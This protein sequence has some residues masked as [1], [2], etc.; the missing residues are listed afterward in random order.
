MFPAQAA[1]SLLCVRRRFVSYTRFQ[2]RDSPVTSLLWFQR[3]HKGYGFPFP[4]SWIISYEWNQQLPVKA[5]KYWLYF[6]VMPRNDE[7]LVQHIWHI[8]K[9]SWCNNNSKPASVLVNNCLS[10]I[11]VALSWHFHSYVFNFKK[12]TFSL[13]SP[14]F[15]DIV[16]WDQGLFVNV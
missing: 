1:T 6:D 16:F 4:A 12:G 15:P 2:H 13:Y 5:N 14:Y 9:R 8:T 7:H 11:S 10:L 3:R